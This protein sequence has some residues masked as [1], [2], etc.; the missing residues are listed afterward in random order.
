[1]L[2]L[3]TFAVPAAAHG[4][5]NRPVRIA[6]VLTALLVAGV[7]ALAVAGLR[8]RRSD[9]DLDSFARLLAALGTL[10]LGLTYLLP[11]VR[12]P[13][14]LL[15]VAAAGV[16]GAAVV[17]LV[18]PSLAVR[19]ERRVV[20]GVALAAAGQA[21][22]ALAGFAAVAV[23]FAVGT[24]REATAWRRQALALFLLVVAA[25]P[26]ALV[27]ARS[28]HRTVD[29]AFA[30]TGGAMVVFGATDLRRLV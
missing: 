24:T 10:S 20:E 3:S 17:A 8:A 27:L 15:A 1:M 23:G 2:A 5:E 22:L 4:P 14:G 30:V 21:T 16:A 25:V 19:P 29:A 26:T 7:V 28:P 12:R 11:A 18:A 9:E 13:D 6:Q